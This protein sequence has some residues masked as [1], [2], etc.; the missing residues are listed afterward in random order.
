MKEKTQT[1]EA[2]STADER[3]RYRVQ[4][5]WTSQATLINVGLLVLCIYLVSSIIAAPAADIAVRIAIVSLV[6]AMPLLAFL[7]ILSEVQKSR[8]YASYPWYMVLA[9]TVAQGAAV[10]GFGAAV[11]HV[12]WPA[13]VALVV[14]GIAGLGLFQAYYRRI[15]RD[16]EPER[17]ARRGSKS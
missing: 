12:W 17:K 9:Q 1:R 16:N 14:S 7:A 13:A 5:E 8:R 15:E 11:W 4:P 10:L 3:G 2:L 6:V